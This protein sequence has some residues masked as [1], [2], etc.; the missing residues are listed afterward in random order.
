LEGVK[1]VKNLDNRVYSNYSDI[2]PTKNNEALSILSKKDICND[3]SKSKFLNNLN[4]E[5]S[6]APDL[7]KSQV[8][9]PKCNNHRKHS[10]NVNVKKIPSFLSGSKANR[11]SFDSVEQKSKAGINIESFAILK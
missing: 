5:E 11:K 6:F 7:T 1:L 10:D 4:L 3:V 8:G 9:S 2:S